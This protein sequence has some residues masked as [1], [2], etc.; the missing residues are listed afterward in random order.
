MKAIRILLILASALALSACSL[1]P[2]SDGSATSPVLLSVSGSTSGSV[3]PYGS[4]YYQVAQ[5]YL[6]YCQLS[7]DYLE[8]TVYLFDDIA[9]IDSTSPSDYLAVIDGAG[10]SEIGRGP[11]YGNGSN[12][13][14][15]VDSQS[16]DGNTYSISFQDN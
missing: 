3:A 14:I 11:I 4:S 16:E 8:L 15:R 7:G 9:K 2:S 6:P 12:I 1:P 5:S 13:Y 10:A